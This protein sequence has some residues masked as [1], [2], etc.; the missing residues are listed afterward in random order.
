MDVLLRKITLGCI[1]IH[2]QMS[3][4]GT[5]L[6]LWCIRMV[7]S[8]DPEKI[9][10]SHLDQQL[11][12]IL[13]ILVFFVFS[14]F[15]YFSNVDALYLF[16]HLFLHLYSLVLCICNS[17]MFCICILPSSVFFTF[18]CWVYTHHVSEIAFQQRGG[19]GVINLLNENTQF[20]VPFQNL[21]FLF[22]I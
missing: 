13:E 5:I 14:H 16:L 21:M 3:C 18:W 6:S 1:C 12:E 10:N 17:L 22:R 20:N 11:P 15:P 7:L 8:K 19:R 4:I 9:L 2:L